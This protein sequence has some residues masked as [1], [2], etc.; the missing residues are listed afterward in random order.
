MRDVDVDVDVDA[1]EITS[2]ILPSSHKNYEFT[3]LCTSYVCT[4]YVLLE[5]KSQSD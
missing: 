3:I 4:M 1:D 5:R 2:G